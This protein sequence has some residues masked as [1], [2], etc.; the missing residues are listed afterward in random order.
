MA[1]FIP[2]LFSGYL[3]GRRDAIKDNW[4][5]LTNYGNVLDKQLDNAYS[6][7]TFGDRVQKSAFETEQE[8]QKTALGGATTDQRIDLILRQMAAG[9][10]QAAVN[11][12]IAQFVHNLRLL[13]DPNY[14][15][16]WYATAGQP[17]QGSGLGTPG[18]PG[19]NGLG[20]T[21]IPQNLGREELEDVEERI[22]KA[23]AKGLI[24]QDDI[25]ATPSSTNGSGSIYSEGG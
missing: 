14:R 6:M 4:T 24:P 23:K 12:Q 8:K 7:Q 16:N 17:K 1:I 2:D 21:N 11:A 13:Q 15:A 5:D 20:S 25:Y 3:Q 9:M 10:N 18:I 19:S 22:K